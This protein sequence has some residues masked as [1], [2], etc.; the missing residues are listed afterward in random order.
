MFNLFKAKTIKVNL[1]GLFLAL[2]D[3]IKVIFII[4][5]SANFHNKVLYTMRYI[6]VKMKA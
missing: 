2:A 6:G 3:I 5:Y 1:L 4:P